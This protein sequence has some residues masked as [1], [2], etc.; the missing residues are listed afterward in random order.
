MKKGLLSATWLVR[1]GTIE[2]M[3][4]LRGVIHWIIFP[5]RGNRGD[6]RVSQP[7]GENGSLRESLRKACS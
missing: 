7:C 2:Q 5:M 4:D 1:M 3:R 6:P